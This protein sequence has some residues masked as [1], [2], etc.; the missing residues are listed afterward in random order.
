MADLRRHDVCLRADFEWG[1]ER[2]EAPLCLVVGFK[3]GGRKRREEKEGKFHRQRQDT[4]PLRVSAT[5]R[6]EGIDA[7]RAYTLARRGSFWTLQMTKELGRSEHPTL[8]LPTRGKKEEK[9]GRRRSW[10]GS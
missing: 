1:G 4:T 9:K 10:H 3:K 8:L 7:R 2:I 6:E 5:K